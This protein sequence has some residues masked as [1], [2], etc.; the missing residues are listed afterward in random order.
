MIR[1][2]SLKLGKNVIVKMHKHNFLPFTWYVTE[3]MGPIEIEDMGAAGNNF[4]KIE[5]FDVEDAQN[6]YI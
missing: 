1:V 5:V 3:Y 4:E 2:K 6:H